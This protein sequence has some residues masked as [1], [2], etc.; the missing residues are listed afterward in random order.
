MWGQPT[1]GSVNR[2]AERLLAKGLL[3][4]FA[5]CDTPNHPIGLVRIAWRRHQRSAVPLDELDGGEERTS[6]VA[7][8]E[9][10]VL[11]EVPAKHGGLG[12]EVRVRLDATEASLRR[13]ERGLGTS[14]PIK[15]RDRLGR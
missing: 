12:L 9:R 1:D 14:D 3:A 4:Y 2:N 13:G 8:R 5:A 10:V 7:V 6:L 15:V 11:D